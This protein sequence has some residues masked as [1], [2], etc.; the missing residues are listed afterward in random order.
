MI[1]DDAGVFHTRAFAHLAAIEAANGGCNRYILP[2]IASK[3][4]VVLLQ[5]STVQWN[6][7]RPGGECHC[8]GELASQDM[9]PACVISP[10]LAGP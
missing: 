2:K 6:W 5:T 4:R 10:A 7:A 1:E 3:E 9:E 8:G